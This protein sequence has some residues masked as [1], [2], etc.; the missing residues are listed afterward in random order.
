MVRRILFGKWKNQKQLES[1]LSL[2]WT[3]DTIQTQRALCPCIYIRGVKNHLYNRVHWNRFNI[4]NETACGC[5]I[6]KLY[7]RIW[8]AFARHT[9][10]I[11]RDIHW[12]KWGKNKTNRLQIHIESF[13]SIKFSLVNCYIVGW[14]FFSLYFLL[15]FYAFIHRLCLLLFACLVCVIFIGFYVLKCGR[16]NRIGMDC[17]LFINTKQYIFPISP[18]SRLSLSK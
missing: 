3:L 2:W 13:D 16:L 14:I 4:S 18:S 1:L 8:D 11:C 7:L 5:N 17:V 6:Y 12:M 10:L 9:V 15:E